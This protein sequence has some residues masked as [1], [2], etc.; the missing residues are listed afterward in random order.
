MLLPDRAKSHRPRPAAQIAPDRHAVP[1]MTGRFRV[2]MV[3]ACPFPAPRGT[4]IR[5]H[6]MADELTRRGH[7]VD[8]FTYHLGARDLDTAF[9]IYRIPNIR[10]YRKQ[11]AGPTY[12]KLLLLD[13]LLA[14]KL[15]RALRRRRYDVLHAHHAEGLLAALPARLLRRVPLV[16]D[17]HTL[18]ETELPYYRLGMTRGLLGRLGRTLDARLPRFA[19]HVIAVSEDIRAALVG[20]LGYPP[21]AVSV[22][23][24]GVEASFH[25]AVAPLVPENADS[26]PTVVYAGNLAPF[27]GVDLLLR[28]FA[29]ARARRPDLRLQIYTDESFR[30]FEP[31]ARELGIS[32]WI[33]IAS[34]ALAELPGRLAAASV[35][36][37][38]RTEPAGAPQKLCNYMAA[39]C[40]IVSFAG[41]AKHIVHGR[42]GLVVP[43]YDLEA[44]ADGMLCLIADRHLAR[45][46]GAEARV[47]ARTELN[48]SRAAARVE[49]VYRQVVRPQAQP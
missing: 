35:A 38:P 44:L 47:S 45:R 1:P 34:V 8:V 14:I 21:Q 2:A 5:I 17:A 24:N 18:L 22:I 6:R 36:V 3:A 13:P 25:E 4:P 7:D 19:D 31:L 42:T 16:F 28:A 41:S 23:P 29:I 26:A 40:P 30:D 15:L 12:Q 39:G 33:G 49:T 48:W 27:Q 9:D 11:S 46:L 10:T 32:E 37:S 43:D 20:R